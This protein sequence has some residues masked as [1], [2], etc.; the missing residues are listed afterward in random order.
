MEQLLKL[1]NQL[2]NP[3]DDDSILQFCLDNAS[4][5]ICDIRNSNKVESKYLNTQISM[6]IEVYNKRGA[7]GQTSH[8]ENGIGRSY[9]KGDISPS[10]IARITPVVKTPFSKVRV[11]E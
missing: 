8:S 7:E 2:G 6:A 11:V 5:I 4:D 3:S 1:K 9:E 10:I